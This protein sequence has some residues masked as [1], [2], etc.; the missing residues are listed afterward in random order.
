MWRAT[1][2]SLL[3]HKVRLALTTLAI[4]FGVAFIAGT[5]IYTDTTRSTFDSVFGQVTGS[6][7]FS[8]R[9]ISQLDGAEGGDQFEIARP[10]VPPEVADRVAAVDG[11]ADVERNVEGVIGLL[12]ADGQPLGSGQGPPSLGFNAP[13]VGDLSPTEL[14]DGRYPSAS[15]EVALDAATAASND[16]AVGDSVR[17][18]VDGPVREYEVVGVFGFGDGVDNMAGASV[19]LFEPDAAF[20][21]F[22]DDGGYASVD[23]LAADGVRLDGVHDAVAAAAGD[24]Y[25]VVTSDELAGE[26]QEAIDTVLGFLGN[27]LLVFAGV[28]LLVGAFLINN[29]FAII[30]AQRSREL[31]LLRAV[32]ASRAQILGSVMLEALIVG[33]FASAVGVGVG[34]LVAGALQQLLVAFG[35]EIPAGDL[36]FAARTVVVGMTLGV[37][38]TLLSALLPAVRALKVPPVAA[39]QTIAVGDQQVGGRIRTV[40]GVLLATAGLGMLAAGLFGAAPFAVVIGGAVALLLGAALLARYVT[41]PLL[42]VVGWPLAR[43]GIRGALAQENAIRSPQR[44]A[45]TASALMIGLGLVTFALIF[46]ASL[47]ESATATIDEQFVSDLQVRTTNFESFPAEVDEEVSALPEVAT[48]ADMRN[49]QI[50]VRG[51]IGI[52]AAIEPDEVASAFRLDTVEGSLDDFPEGGLVLSDDA[53][54]RLDVGAGDTLPVTFATGGE[55]DLPI[56]AVID[57]GGLDVDY[58]VDEA[59]MLANAPDD[60]VFNLYVTV[61]DGVDIEQA[62]SAI[63]GVTNDYAALAVQDST[64]YKEEIAGQVDQILGLISA[65]L[66]LSV[67][68]ALFGITNTLSLSVFERV[69]ELGLLRAVGATRRQVRSMVRWESVLIAVLGAVFGITVGAVFGWM[70]VQALAEQGVSTFAFPVG[71]IALAVL[72]AAIAGTLA[73]VLPARR[74]ARVDV[75]RALA[76]T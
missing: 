54:D 75:L 23:V 31:A 68:I 62:R 20:E 64:E 11:V 36:V 67:L 51:R 50:G 66:G 7:D 55:Q 28:S 6:V 12:G 30:V 5:L 19:T 63:E 44:T 1:L 27:A 15:D 33:T 65:L 47:R 3:A 29:T 42:R 72:A 10:A 34:V 40:L 45:S 74:A 17:I 14:R 46:G 24:G 70:S 69:R 32:G 58:I 25:E 37:V 4:V 71:Q 73:A 43:L 22:A 76:T 26:A 39:M 8:V 16:F 35:I 48:T 9:G 13:T 57:G 60:G 21:L 38:V 41:R 61:A 18:A 2:S 52:A 49:G 56:R 53:A 59:T